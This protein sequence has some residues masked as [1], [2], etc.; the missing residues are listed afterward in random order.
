M[1]SC[2]Q[3]DVP[4]RESKVFRHVSVTMSIYRLNIVERLNLMFSCLLI[5][6]IN[7]LHSL[8]SLSSEI[9]DVKFLVCEHPSHVVEKTFE[10]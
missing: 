3:T 2:P 8:T 1:C 5:V 7:R 10:I 4:I 9:T 6:R